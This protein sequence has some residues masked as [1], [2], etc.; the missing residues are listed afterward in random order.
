MLAAVG[1][2]AFVFGAYGYGIFVVMPFLI[3]TVT[4]IIANVRG[5]AGARSTRRIVL[6]TLAL[7]A[8][9]LIA[10]AM[11]G[12]VCILMTIPIAVPVSFLG[13]TIGRDLALTRAKP[14]RDALTSASLLP[15]V[16]LLEVFL[17]AEIAFETR[18]EIAI[19][20]APEAVWETLIAMDLS[21]YPVPPLFQLGLAYPIR[22]EIDAARVGAMRYGEFST[23]T[24]VEEITVWE[25][26][27][28]LAFRVLESP[29]S[30]REISPYQNVHAPHVNGFLETR[31]TSFEIVPL[32]DGSSKLIERTS[33][34]MRLD[35][36][37][38]WL[39]IARWVIGANNARVLA[40]IRDSAEAAP[41]RT[42]L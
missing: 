41:A 34:V 5:D 37:V 2:G 8:V 23:G 21:D 15:L 42:R 3:G 40:Y 22:G 12:V 4:G 19:A 24:A 17:P 11:E 10:V 27:R 29:P 16:L 33:H 13:A 35:P 20:A 38:Y 39:P 30:M 31:D 1:L 25:E 14:R 36:A 18:Q 6:V 28:E 7:G 9:V 26:N 32:D